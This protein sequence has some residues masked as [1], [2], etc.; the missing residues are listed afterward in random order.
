MIGDRGSGKTVLAASAIQN[1]RDSSANLV[2]YFFFEAGHPDEEESPASYRSTA[3]CAILSQILQQFP[4]DNE[5]LDIFSYSMS[6]MED[7]NYVS[8]IMGMEDLLVL[9]CQRVKKAV[10]VLDEIEECKDSELLMLLLQRIT[11]HSAIKLLLFG[12]PSAEKL[13]GEI[14]CKRKIS[15]SKHN[16]RDIRL[17]LTN[18]LKVLKDGKHI[19]SN[20]EALEMMNRLAGRA[21]GIFLWAQL[22]WAYISSPFLAIDSR[23]EIMSKTNLSKIS[24]KTCENI[25]RLVFSKGN[26]ASTL[27]KNTL[28]WLLY[29]RQEMAR[30]EIEEALR[31]SQVDWKT[32]HKDSIFDFEQS[33]IESC[34]GLVEIGHL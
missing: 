4:L 31:M 18:K 9:L 19:S 8:R 12:G 16:G 24:R 26:P 33:V 32:A 30:P 15:V 6:I 11:E 27:A 5:I 2:L 13:A 7:K 28:M 23:E 1:L 22:F 14:M 25:P 17:F 21:G 3:Y 20:F 10:L 29:R 34:G